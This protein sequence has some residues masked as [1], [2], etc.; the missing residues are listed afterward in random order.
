MSIRSDLPALEGVA[1]L[2]SGTNGPMP[3]PAADAMQA[4]IE[5]AASQPAHRPPGVRPHHASCASA[6]APPLGRVVGAPP[7]QIALTN[8]TTQGI[9]AVIAGID[10]NAGRRGA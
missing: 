1:Y 8:S 10:W 5:A 9:G 2:N 7:E 4:E 3:R 6:P